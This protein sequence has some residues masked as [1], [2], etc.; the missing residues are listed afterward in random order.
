MYARNPLHW[1][2]ISL[3]NRA[4]QH[5][6]RLVATFRLSDLSNQ[7]QEAGADGTTAAYA[8]CK[9]ASI[10]PQ[11][12]GHV[13]EAVARTLYQEL[14][15]ASRMSSP[16]PGF[17][18]NGS[19]RSAWQA[20]YDWLCDGDRVQCKSAQL[21]WHG[22]RS[23]WQFQFSGVK[24][25][26]LDR[27]VLVMYS[28]DQVL[29]VEHDGRNGLVAT[30]VITATRGY[31][32]KYVAPRGTTCHVEAV[33]SICTRIEQTGT[34]RKLFTLRTSHNIVL[35]ALSK[36]EQSSKYQLES[37]AFQHHPFQGKS[38]SLR[39]LIIQSMVQEVDRLLHPSLVAPMK[40]EYGS[41]CDWHHRGKRVECKHSRIAWAK[42]RGWYCRF[43]GIK[44][45]HFDL[46]YLALDG[47]DALHILQY[48]GSAYMGN[49]GV[50]S[51]TVGKAITVAGPAR[52]TDCRVSLEVIMKK[53]CSSGSKHVASVA[54]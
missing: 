48:S 21:C 18:C 40:G 12:R 46:L 41:K 35:Q 11:M 24:L 13:F 2:Y 37:L 27:L 49:A 3:V 7:F 31:Q 44:P 22:G 4:S 45:Q 30:G 6:S 23:H 47:P 1:R 33:S 52:E 17:D 50:S 34:C 38:P 43:S 29:L 39:G 16:V 8:G 51:D 54:W 53:L 10:T 20:E 14:Y 26:L 36:H 32:V 19:R 28:P 5:A 15:P 42:G 9:L 25:A